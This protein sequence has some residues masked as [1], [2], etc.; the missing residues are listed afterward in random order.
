[1]CLHGKS[2]QADLILV[3]RA[4]SRVNRGSEQSEQ[5]SEQSSEQ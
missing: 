5:S 3:N 4:V 2:V 1:M